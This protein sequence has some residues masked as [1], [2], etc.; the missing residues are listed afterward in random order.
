VAGDVQLLVRTATWTLASGDPAEA[1]GLLD[2]A[3]RALRGGRD[4]VERLAMWSDD[5]RAHPL[6]HTL[7][8]GAAAPRA[9]VAISVLN[10]GTHYVGVCRQH[11]C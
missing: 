3:S 2:T 1:V 7:L 10:A 9:A 5:G 6:A 11:G 4:G 8:A